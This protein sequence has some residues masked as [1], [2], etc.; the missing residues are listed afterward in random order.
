M[1]DK[2]ANPNSPGASRPG[3]TTC[4][5]R[6][7]PLIELLACQPK[8]AG[9]RQARSA[10]TLIELLVVIAIIGLLATL[11]LPALGVIK[12]RARAAKAQ[13]RIMELSQGCNMFKRATGYYPGQLDSDQ[14]AGS[15]P[16]GP[17]TGSQVLAA[18]MFEYS[19]DKIGDA[20]SGATEG[21]A[22][23]SPSDLIS[24]ESRRNTISDRFGSSVANGAMALL[25]YPSRLGVTG[26]NQ[27]KEGDNAAYT[28]G[29][30][31]PTAGATKGAN[32]F[33][34]YI[35]SQKISGVNSTTPYNDGEFL[36]MAAGSDREY[37][38]AYDV[39]N[40]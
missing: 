25:Y 19:Y 6:G 17:Y 31:W 36:L 24:V 10:F 38:T 16:A 2:N 15:T 22:S 26:L 18:C 8:P 30:N 11:F 12:D 7:F 39:K 33:E 23:L 9:R 21:Y 35:T 28:G 27:Y 4:A 13:A 20:D 32:D 14:L 37:G 1:R 3:Q 29:V 34:K 40:W 5:G